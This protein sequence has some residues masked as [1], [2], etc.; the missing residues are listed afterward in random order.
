MRESSILA[1]VVLLFSVGLSPDASPAAD[2]VLYQ[3]NHGPGRG[4]HNLLVKDRELRGFVLEAKLR[5]PPGTTHY[6]LVF[7]YTDAKHFYRLVLRPRHQDFRV[8]KVVGQSDYA[9]TRYVAFPMLTNRWY[10]VRLVVRGAEVEVWIDGTRLYESDAFSELT[11]GLAGV[12]V[13][14]PAAA[15]FD[16]IRIADADAQENLFQA[17][18]D[19][20]DLDAWVVAG[21]EGVKG[22]WAVRPKIEK[23]PSQREFVEDR[24]FQVCPSTGRNQSMF[25]F[26]GVTK[27]TDGQLLT[28]FIEENQHGTPPWAAMPSSGK[29][30]M[31]RSAD[32]ARSWSKPTPFLDTPIDDRHAY[33]LQLADGDLLAFFWVQPVAFGLRGLFN[34]TT[35]SSDGG[36][37]WTDPLRVRSGRPAWPPAQAV[38]VRG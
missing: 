7:R 22:Q 31:A 8:E 35:R 30:W 36:L 28:L 25:E 17:D 15:E 23:V 38:G 19:H 11:T 13:F 18:F 3:K 16:D 24:T 10:N 37:T 9:T 12:T 4:Y 29:L 20:D 6:G 2:G 26:P 14:D 33:T 34:F 32:M 1:A 21:P 5:H 27:L